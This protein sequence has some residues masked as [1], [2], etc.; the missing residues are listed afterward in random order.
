MNVSETVAAQ[1]AFFRTGVT[2]SDA[3]RRR[4]LEKLL[5]AMYEWEQALCD[6][7]KKDL[8]KSAQESY[9]RSAWSAAR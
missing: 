4:Q 6:A 7:L 8:H 2:L 5:A 1:K 3:F 9:M